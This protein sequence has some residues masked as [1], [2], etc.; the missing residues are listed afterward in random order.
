M[1]GG[2]RY[3]VP[4]EFAS[5]RVKSPDF[6]RRTDHDICARIVNFCQCRRAP[7]VTESITVGTPKF[8]ARGFVESHDGARFRAS[9]DDDDVTRD[10]GTG[11]RSPFAVIGFLADTR[12]PKLIAIHVIRENSGLAEKHVDVLAV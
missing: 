4:L 10:D 5:R 3:A 7:D 2:H 8:L 12:L 11:R 1:I 6:V 9:G